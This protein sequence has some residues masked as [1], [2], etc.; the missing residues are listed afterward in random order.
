MSFQSRHIGPDATQVASMLE[1]VGCAS[2]E[3]LIDEAVPGAIR[4]G[5]PLDLPGPLSERE[6]LAALAERAEQNQVFRSLIGMG[7]HNTFTPPVIQRNVF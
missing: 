7:Y 2:L 6:A 3:Q 4:L 1:T 5:R